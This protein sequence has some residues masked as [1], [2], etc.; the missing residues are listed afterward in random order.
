[1]CYQENDLVTRNCTEGEWSPAANELESCMN[2]LKVSDQ[3]S[4]IFGFQQ[5][6]ENKS[7][8]CFQVS[9]PTSWNYPCFSNGGASVITELDASETDSLIDLLIVSNIS[10]YY[11]LPAKRPKIF[12]PV[13]WYIPGPNWGQTVK[14]NDHLRLQ[15][16]FWKNCLALDVQQR[17][18]ITETCT[19]NYPGLC[20]YQ[21]NI[22]YRAVCPE[23]YH[24]FRYKPDNGTCYGIEKSDSEIGLTFHNFIDK[25]CHRPMRDDANSINRYIFTEIADHNNLPDSE[26][27]WFKTLNIDG[28]EGNDW[29]TENLEGIINNVGVLGFINSSSLMT[30]MACET[31]VIYG[32]TELMF[33]FNSQNNKIYLTVYFP[34]G[35]WKYDHDDKG[36]QCFSDAKGFVRVIDISL[37]PDMSLEREEDE[38]SYEKV[39]Y[40]VDLITNRSAQYWCEAHTFNFTFISTDK[41]IVNPK[42]Q[43]VHVFSLTLYC[44]NITSE[45]QNVP[46][47]TN[48]LGVLT[49]TLNV[50]ETLLM[51]VFELTNTYILAL[52]HVH[53]SVDNI[54]EDEAENILARYN[55]LMNDAIHNLPSV[56]CS[57]VNLT[58]SVYCLPTSTKSYA[59]N[60]TLNW[61]LTPIGHISAPRQFCL[62]SNGL[63][64]KR[65]CLGSYHLGG[66]WGRV[67]G[68][69]DDSYVPSETTTFL[70]NVGTGQVSDNDTASFL[71]EGL[72]FVL[73]G[74]GLIIPADIYYLSISLK[75][76]T[77]LAQNNK[78]C[79]DLGD[80]DNMAW[81]MNRVMSLEADYMRLAQT[82]NSTNVILNSV[83]DIIEM[84]AEKDLN[85]TMFNIGNQN[86][87]L[88]DIDNA[89]QLAVEPQFIVQISYPEYSN[90]TG[91]AVHKLSSKDKFTDMI[92]KPLY[93]NTTL[94]E[95]F[96]FENL[97]VATWLPKK[98]LM[99]LKANRN[100][101]EQETE[102]KKLLHIIVSVFKNDVVFQELNKKN[103]IIN[104]HIVGI[105][106]PGYIPNLIY[107]IPLVFRRIN[108]T[109]SKDMCGFWDFQSY[110]STKS[111]GLWETKGCIP[112]KSHFDDKFSICKCYHLTH[113][114]QLMP[115]TSINDLNLDHF[116]IQ[117]HTRALNIITLVGCFLSLCGVTGIWIT[118][119]IFSNWRR[120][121]GTK[122]LLQLSTAI[123]LPLIFIVVSNIDDKMFQKS[124]H[125]KLFEITEKY[126]ILCV[127]LGA[128][129]HYSILASFVWMLI[130]A[131]LQFVRYVRVLGISR[132]SRFMFKFALIGWGIPIIPVI[133]ILI[134]NY[135]SYIPNPSISKPMCYP[136]G[137]YF[138]LGVML[139]VS[140]ILLVN[141]IL[142]ILVLYSIARGSND[143]MK[144]TDMD[145]VYA[146]FRLS[147][148]L[149][150]LL[151]LTWIFGIFSFTKNPLW[152]YL[153]CL[154]S[155]LQGFV[156]FIYFIICDPAARGMWVTLVKPS[157]SANSF[158][159]SITSTTS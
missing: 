39:V 78:T 38:S 73:S 97:E 126:E 25:K 119:M 100:E 144:S 109:R 114:S 96:A 20:F 40:T 118:A 80:V 3:D 56:N 2:V 1:M 115:I 89:Y 14:D 30:C 13:V 157:F 79:I 4:C 131:V 15:I 121:A 102:Q 134:I 127:V 103:H 133:T 76:I 104:S 60:L 82:L 129:L 87:S 12:H 105:S 85:D 63:P 151:G 158:R 16:S 24:P 37:L 32:E 33:E 77:F 6:S 46:D 86:T 143:K 70:Y 42:G 51:D 147:I 88:V 34:S 101:S 145:L 17:S 136:K 31:D 112:V 138:L 5:I 92:I 110:N 23:G 90:V 135:E 123:A 28:I 52:L 124:I 107:P 125:S 75:Q 149:F 47:L 142:F 130:T 29:G 59:S 8:Y 71:T 50:K 81:V 137:I 140:I 69:C 153:F 62:Q 72:G 150:F 146:Q 106:I 152:S 159:N 139:P 7:D 99:S 95:V 94:E 117:N 93:A 10:R 45:M 91:L 53:A 132:P 61:S 18:I 83:N 11:W 35:L 66:M 141:I 74:E 54:Y 128:L 44:Y 26:W 108:Q 58:S 156:I 111:L 21:N 36:I 116:Q 155:T 19:E 64:V 68:E 148:F 49:Q 48:I 84:I 67:E 9:P 122:V 154:T 120:K 113:F 57:F 27:C 22:H 41:I 55:M 43:A 98:L 65:Q